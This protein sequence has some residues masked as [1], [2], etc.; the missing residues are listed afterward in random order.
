[1]ERR[2]RTKVLT[3]LVGA[4]FAALMS[5]ASVA[6][7]QVRYQLDSGFATERFNNSELDE[8]EDNWVANSYQV[9]KGGTHIVAVEFPIGTAYSD[10]PASA[11]IYQGFDLLDPSAGGGL[12]RL[13][14]TDLVINSQPGDLITVVLDTPVD[15]NV[16]D[17]FYVAVLI[18]QVQFPGG[19][20][21]PWF[22]DGN[23]LLNR[24]FFDVG[25]AQGAPYDLDNTANATVNGATHPVVGDG[26]QSPGT[27]FIRAIATDGT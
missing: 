2:L 8:T 1:M 4:A 13:S 7:A 20:E 21:F 23:T 9:V 27:T 24:S 10:K 19:M 14:T 17:I 22:N 16:D 6:R 18:P 26:V 3:V 12:I 5:Q 11:V 25:P 15:L